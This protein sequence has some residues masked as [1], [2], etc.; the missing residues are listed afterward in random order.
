M[1]DWLAVAL[2]KYCQS[3]K[4]LISE[5][6]VKVAK[7]NLDAL[8]KFDPK[9]PRYRGRMRMMIGLQL[10]ATRPILKGRRRSRLVLR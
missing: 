1:G 7:D 4:G 8:P 9:K 10:R 5:K 6:L 2:A 3:D